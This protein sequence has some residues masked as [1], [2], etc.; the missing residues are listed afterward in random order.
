MPNPYEAS[1]CH[2]IWSC[3]DQRFAASSPGCWL[4]IPYAAVNL[5]HTIGNAVDT[6]VLPL[7]SIL[8]PRTIAFCG[9]LATISRRGTSD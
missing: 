5:V 3:L 9:I 2:E 4:R 1:L 7:Q 6:R 8:L